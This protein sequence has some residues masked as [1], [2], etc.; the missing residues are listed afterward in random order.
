VRA[1]FVGGGILL[2]VLILA[3]VYR[4]VASFAASRQAAAVA[5]RTAEPDDGTVHITVYTT[6]WC[7]VCKRAKA[8][9]NAKG[10]AYE[11][12]DVESNPEYARQFRAINARGGVP[13]FD[14]D[15]EIVTGFSDRA[16]SGA[17]AKA[18]ERRAT[19]L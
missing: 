6:Q 1:L 11:E 8:W 5:A 4:V 2:T 18:K 15:G 7:P 10:Y 12:R 13:T 3:S 17:I 16:V 14:I 19:S 9:M